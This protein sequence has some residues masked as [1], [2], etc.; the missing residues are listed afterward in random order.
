[1]NAYPEEVMRALMILL[2][3]MGL[4]AGLRGDVSEQVSCRWGSQRFYNPIDQTD[5]S[6]YLAKNKY[7]FTMQSELCAADI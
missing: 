7:A 4:R 5:V 1:M 6:W 2:E 3:L